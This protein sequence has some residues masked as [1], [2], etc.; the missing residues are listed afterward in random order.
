MRCRFGRMKTYE[1]N[2]FRFRLEFPDTWKLTSWHHAQIARSWQSAYQAKDDDLPKKGKCA[3]KFLFTAALH[4]PESEAIVD[5]DIELSVF[6]LSQIEDMRTSLVEN[7]ERQR[8]YYESNGIVTSIVNEGAWNLGGIDFTY[9]DQESK[10]RR[11]HSWYRFF[12]RPHDE[13]FWL[14]G[15]IAGHKR[16][17]YD[18]ALEIVSGFKSTAETIG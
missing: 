11:K 4:P 1:N 13:V 7:F 5:A 8:A 14:Y 16:Q 15:K 3:T 12:F 2:F 9:V 17:A 6:R 18:H 10:S